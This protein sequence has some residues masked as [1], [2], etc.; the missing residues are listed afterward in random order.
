[1]A[2]N[3][4]ETD[5]LVIGGGG[6]GFRAAVGA[7]EKGA[8]A[9]LVSKGP[10]ARCGATPMAGADFTLDGNSLN[11]LN[12]N[13]D[14]EDSFEKMFNDIVTQGFYLNNQKLVEQYIRTA[15]VCL[16]ELLDWGLTV[17]FSEE[18]AI[19][20]TGINIMD[21]LL[22][23]ARS[24]GA[25]LMEDTMILD[26]VLKDGRIAG[27]LGIDIASGEFVRFKTKAVVMATGGWHK[28]FWPNTGMRDL[29]GEGIAMAARAGADVGNMEFV[30]FC[31]NIFYDPPMWKG[32]LAPYIL[33]ML[34]GHTLTN[35][36]KEAF[37]NAY[38]PYVVETASQ[39]EWNKSFISLASAM[40]AKKGLG[41]PN[42]G[43]YFSR[44]DIPWENMAF[45]AQVMF[46]NWKYKGLDLSEWGK[47]LESNEPVEVGPAVE[48]FDGGIVVDE[49]FE[50][51]VAGLFAAGECTLGLFGANRVFSA[52]TEMLVQG[53]DA[54][55]N[56]GA[57]AMETTTDEPV[58]RDFK[59][60]EEMAQ[61]PL[62]QKSEIHPVQ[63][64]REVQQK[65][66]SSLGPLRNG[67]DLSQFIDYLENVKT[68]ILPHL[69]TASENRVY[70]KEWI[71]VLE[72]KNM[73]QLLEVSAKSALLRRESRGV[74]FREDYSAADNDQWLVET[75]AG[76]KNDTVDITHRPVTVTAMTPPAGTVAYLDMMKAL[77]QAHSDIGGHH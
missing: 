45:Y 42:G 61:K 5:V 49:G 32:S 56:A 75:I 30:T 73:V 59:S 10:L 27:A 16:K 1:M 47:K 57:Y 14:P 64:M 4:M 76:F 68:R 53:V 22:K 51:G 70:N 62:R 8:E 71:C 72:L 60:I 33:G 13:G 65:A 37:L 7:R 6:A 36:K 43:I 67:N 19:F 18:R 23:K 77:M 58:D 63:V 12:F 31:C 11:R 69:G 55:Q 35:S 54:G 40:E 3:L 52:I 24:M 26:L 41:G 17:S 38:D 29:S 50:T 20:T 34:A 9:I 15:P 28:A 2:N 66:H 48:Y 39:T 21:V 44:G 25:T 46:P 74:H